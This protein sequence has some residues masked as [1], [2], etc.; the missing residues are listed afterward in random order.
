MKVYLFLKMPIYPNFTTEFL[1]LVTS[2][3]TS[4][5]DWNIV[6]MFLIILDFIYECTFPHNG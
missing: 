3:M 6:Q 5:W 2:S 1:K 4:N